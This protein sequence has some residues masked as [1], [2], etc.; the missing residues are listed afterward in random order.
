MA[1]DNFLWFP[2]PAAGGM[3][4]GGNAARPKGETQDDWM[5]KMNAL[6]VKSFNFGITMP[7][8]TGSMSGGSSG[9]KAQFN[10][11]AI[12]KN[13]DLASV[14]LYQAATVGA[15]FPFVFLAIR[16]AGGVH[17]LYL[18]YIFA[19]VFIT[20]IEWSGGSGDEPFSESISFK[21]GAIGIQYQK[22]EATGQAVGAPQIANWSIID[23]APKL[24]VTGLPTP[25]KF[26]GVSQA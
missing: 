7:H 24:A 16:K 12:T 8:T 9:G 1:C 5:S 19:Q 23:N 20:K 18:Q 25:P 2:N 14:P 3:L 22:Q 21:Y 15:H 6:E 17:L 4:S 10:E 13:V 11:F 26:I